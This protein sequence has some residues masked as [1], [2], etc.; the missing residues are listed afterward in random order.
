MQE[1][2]A[3]IVIESAGGLLSPLG[4]DFDTR[5]LIRA[6]R[7]RPVVVA[8]NRLGTV[9]QVRLVLEALPRGLRRSAHVVLVR[10][11]GA[12]GAATNVGLLSEFF[13]PSQ[14]HEMPWL[15]FDVKAYASKSARAL[16]ELVAALSA[17]HP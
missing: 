6:L 3:N 14:I 13:P 11:P 2:F 8:P 4:D 7:A 9:N 5:D 1:T 10:H 16:S 15:G 17:H 12:R